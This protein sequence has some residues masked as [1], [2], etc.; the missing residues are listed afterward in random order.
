MLSLIQ[1]CQ[2]SIQIITIYC[3]SQYVY[4]YS[5][6]AVLYCIAAENIAIQ[7]YFNILL[8]LYY[9]QILIHV[10]RSYAIDYLKQWIL[11]YCDV[12]CLLDQQASHFVILC[13]CLCMSP[14]SMANQV[15]KMYVDKNLCIFIRGNT[16]SIVMIMCEN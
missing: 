12:S 3:N 10:L 8:H 6:S 13:Q 9:Q 11:K 14:L 2:F 4:R 7:Q 1:F 16:T 5:K 15:K